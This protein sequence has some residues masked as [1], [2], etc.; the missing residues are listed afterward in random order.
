MHFG[1]ECVASLLICPCMQ[2]HGLYAAVSPPTMANEQTIYFRCLGANH[3][4]FV[5]F[6]S[7]QTNNTI[8]TTN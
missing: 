6:W 7:F 2:C 1:A 4:L 5:N 8:F 3:A